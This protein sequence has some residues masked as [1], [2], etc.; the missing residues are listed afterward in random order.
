MADLSFLKGFEKDLEDLELDDGAAEPPT[1]WFSTGN[2]VA[3][4]TL[5]GSFLNGIPQGRV[6]AYVGPSGC[7]KSFLLANTMREAQKNGA[8]IVAIDSENA[9]DNEFVGKIGVDTSRS[10]YKYVDVDTIPDVVRVVSSF[11][12]SYKAAYEPGDPEAPK[13]LVCID[14]LNMLSTETEAENFEKGIAKGDQGQTNKQLKSML[15]S[16]VRAIKHYNISI[17]CTAHVYKNQDVLNGEGVWIVADAIKYA[18]SHVALLTKLKL[19]AGEGAKRVAVGIE[20]KVEG[21][22]TRFTRPYQ[23]VKIEVPY[24][25]GM[26]PYNGLFDVALELGIITKKGS[27]YV[28]GDGENFRQDDFYTEEFASIRSDVLIKCEASTTKFLE[29]NLKDMEEVLDEENPSPKS[30]RKEKHDSK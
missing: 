1:Y 10:A 9:L 21:Y 16:F 17:V 26:D 8:F 2:Y 24:E 12:K 5:S 22:K 13:V 27:W 23:T 4:K 30:K 29:A 3:N 18:L 19:R 15:K 28:I 11:L 7:G 6:A 20:L 14:S 25:T